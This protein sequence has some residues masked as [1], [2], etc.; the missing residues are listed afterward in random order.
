[1]IWTK[2]QE[3]GNTR[4]TVKGSVRIENA[5]EFQRL[6]MDG[7]ATTSPMEIDLNEAEGFDLL[8]IQVLLSAQ[9]EA[10]RNRTCLFITSSPPAFQDFLKFLGLDLGLFHNGPEIEARS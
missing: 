10:R 1:M 9:K 5:A 2:S 4:L 6:I 3:G 8:T 7:M